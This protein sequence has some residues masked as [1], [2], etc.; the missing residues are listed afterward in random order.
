[1]DPSAR[2]VQLGGGR[3]EDP[4]GTRCLGTVGAFLDLQSAKQKLIFM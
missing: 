2:G 1:M 4:A 3:E